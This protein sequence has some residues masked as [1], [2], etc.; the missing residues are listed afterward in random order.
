M[1]KLRL[2]NVK[3]PVQDCT[4]AAV[5]FKPR[6]ISL[7]AL[8]LPIISWDANF[9]LATQN[10]VHGSAASAALGRLAIMQTLRYHTDLLGHNMHFNKIPR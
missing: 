6:V 9:F 10:A 7:K 4:V 3:E 1:R 2:G 5:D 8:D